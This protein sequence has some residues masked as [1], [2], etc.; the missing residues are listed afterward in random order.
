[1]LG[2]KLWRRCLLLSDGLQEVLVVEVLGLWGGL[3][4]WWRRGLLL[5]LG[6][7]LLWGRRLWIRLRLLLLY[8]L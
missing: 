4:R 7:L 2:R 6:L 3:L 1:M 5:L 8:W